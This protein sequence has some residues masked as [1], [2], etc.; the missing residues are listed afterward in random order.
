MGIATIVVGSVAAVAA[1]VAA[2]ATV[3][4]NRVSRETLKVAKEDRNLTTRA[5]DAAKVDRQRQAL[6]EIGDVIESLA[7]WTGEY[8]FQNFTG[9]E[10]QHE[11][12]RLKHLLVGRE[13]SLPNCHALGDASS[14]QDAGSKVQMARGEVGLALANL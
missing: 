4:G 7:M 9:N 1:V 10:W 11:C 14:R 12:N 2:V 3:R 5:S 8:R 6:K 13:D